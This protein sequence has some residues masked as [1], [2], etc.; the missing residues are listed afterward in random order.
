MAKIQAKGLDAYL[1]KLQNLNQSTDAVCKAGVYAGAKVMADKIKAAVDTIPIH[2][3]PSGQEQYYAHPNG[4][5]MNGL[6]R[7]QADDLKKGFGIAAFRHENF[8]WNTKLGF[9]G[10]NSIKTKGHPNGQPNALIARCVEGGTSVWEATPFVA[11][12]VREG[13]KETKEAMKQAVDQK[14]KET[15]DK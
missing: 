7:Q 15:I 9:D 5:P 10:Y 3:L 12:T 14:I 1:K 11:P 8:A 6:S 13:R 2:S 4:P